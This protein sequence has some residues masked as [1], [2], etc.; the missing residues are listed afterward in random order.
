[1]SNAR[2]SVWICCFCAEPVDSAGPA[3]LRVSLT[4]PGF[5]GGQQWMAHESCVAE[6]VHGSAQFETDVYWTG[7]T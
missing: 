7:A 4:K 2:G 3:V 6:A 5:E 1:M